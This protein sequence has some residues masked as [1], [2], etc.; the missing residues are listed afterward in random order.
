YPTAVHQLVAGEVEH[1]T[2][3]EEL[4]VL[5]VALTRAKRR[6]ILTGS[7][8][9]VAS[10]SNSPT[11]G[12]SLGSALRITTARTPLDWILPVLGSAPDGFLSGMGKLSDKPT[13]TVCAHAQE[14]MQAWSMES[15]LDIDRE[16]LLRSVSRFQHLPAEE[17]RIFGSEI[18][19]TVA[20]I[21]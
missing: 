17:P 9:Y 13:L 21:H 14:E 12:S 3:E 6:L 19:Q 5:Y 15:A 10:W 1:S 8:N 16:N 18:A 2:R 7:L 20:R 4:R 11:S